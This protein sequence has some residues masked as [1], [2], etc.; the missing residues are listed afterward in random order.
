M[1]FFVL[2]V[3]NTQTNMKSYI[4]KILVTGESGAGKTTLLKRYIN[5]VFDESNVLTIGVDF[6]TK[7]L[8]F[9]NV[10]CLETFLKVL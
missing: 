9:D 2:N 4:F 5:D 6:F 7:E 1:C 3:S 10:E 8:C